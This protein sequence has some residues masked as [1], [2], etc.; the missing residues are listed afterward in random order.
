MFHLNP[1][2]DLDEVALPGF[3]IEQELDCSRIHISDRLCQPKGRVTERFALLIAQEQRRRS[4]NDF[5]IPALN[6]TVPFIKMNDVSMLVSE[7][8]NLNVARPSYQFFKINLRAAKCR[9][10][11]A[12]PQ[13]DR[14]QQPVLRFDHPH[15]AAATAP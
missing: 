9:L 11:L 1:G 5:L 14:C 15:A 10:G 7:Y 4:F 12:T 2:I 13:V 8:L 6:G 3:V